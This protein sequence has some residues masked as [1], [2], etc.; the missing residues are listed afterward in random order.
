MLETFLSDVASSVAIGAAASFSVILNN[1][2][3]TTNKVHGRILKFDKRIVL[4]KLSATLHRD[5]KLVFY[6]GI[7]AA[8]AFFA[9]NEITRLTPTFFAR[10]P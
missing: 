8:A 1:I 5:R 9:Y 3:Y 6:P 7:A 10:I 2:A 4:E